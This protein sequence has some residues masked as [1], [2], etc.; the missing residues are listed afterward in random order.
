M[1]WL[2]YTLG[3]GYSV[4]RAYAHETGVKLG[5]AGLLL[6]LLVIVIIRWFVGA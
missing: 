3:I 6:A 2:F 1:G 5:C 4:V